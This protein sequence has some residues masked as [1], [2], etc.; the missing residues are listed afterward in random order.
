MSRILVVTY[1]FTGTSL[2]L[3]QRLC[4]LHGW[5]LAEIQET[6]PRTGMLSTWR[7]V[8]DSLLHRKPS[9]SYGGPGPE[10][11]DVVVLISPIWA[12]RLAGPMRTFVSQHAAQLNHVAV[13]SVMASR[14]APNAVAEVGRIAGKSPVLTTSFTAREVDDG[15]CAAALD[16]FGPALVAAVDRGRPLRPAEWSPRAA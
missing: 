3:A 5:D 6:R 9:I 15:T 1:S 10:A 4:G 8:L 2:R 12:E 13:I 7:C 16:A 11:Y 14:G